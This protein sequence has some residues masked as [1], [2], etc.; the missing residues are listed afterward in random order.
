[1]VE[2]II[3]E[4]INTDRMFV[5]PSVGVFRFTEGEINEQS[6]NDRERWTHYHYSG[7]LWSLNKAF[8]PSEHV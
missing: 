4:L 5:R 8:I 6:G 3:I 7:S 2:N 1:M